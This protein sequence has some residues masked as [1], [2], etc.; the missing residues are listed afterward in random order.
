VEPSR[1]GRQVHQARRLTDAHFA[2]FERCYG[3][4]PNGRAKRKPKDS[5]PEKGYL[6]GDRWRSFSLAEVEERDFK[7]DSF[8][9][10]KDES[11]EDAGELPPPEELT[12]DAISELEGAAEELNALLALLETGNGANGKRRERR[13]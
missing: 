12:N 5:P 13:A 9:W 7:L 10:L 2:E 8:K 3:A 1:P 6:G 11:L 4:D